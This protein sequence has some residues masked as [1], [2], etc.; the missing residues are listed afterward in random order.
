MLSSVSRDSVSTINASVNSETWNKEP[1]F[2]GALEFTIKPE[3][4]T[5][6][7]EKNS[8]MRT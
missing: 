7:G 5:V 8:S 3:C 6:L 4:K 2:H 1:A